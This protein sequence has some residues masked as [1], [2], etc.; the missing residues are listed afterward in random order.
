MS[1]MLWYRVSAALFL[2]LS[3]SAPVSAQPGL[4]PSGYTQNFDSLG[5]DGTSPPEGWIVYTLAGSNGTFS[6]ATGIPADRVSLFGLSATQS[7]GLIARLDPASNQNNGYNAATSDAPDDRALATAPTGV[8]AAVLELTLTNNTGGPQNSLFI[9]Y[10]IRRFTVGAGTPDAGNGPGAD[11]LPGYWLFYSLDDGFT[12][13]NVAA[14]NP[15]IN[16]VPNTVGVTHMQTVFNLSSALANGSNIMLRWVDD[17][18]VPSSPDQILGLDNVSLSVPTHDLRDNLVVHLTFDGDVLDHTGRGNDG[19]IVRGGVDSPFVPGIITTNRVS[20]SAFRTQGTY[21]GPN[22]PT[23]NYITLGNPADLDFGE[24]IDITF[25]YWGKYAQSGADWDP[26]WISNK[27]WDSGGNVGYVLSY[28]GRGWIDPKTGGFKWNYK[29]VNTPRQDS[30][31]YPQGGLDDDQW[32]HYVVTFTRQGDGV[33]YIDGS[34]VDRRPLFLTGILGSL[35]SGLPV[36]VMQDGK[37]TYT[38]GGNGSAWYDALISDLGIWRRA[39]TADEVATI[40][41][42]GLQGISAFDPVP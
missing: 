27:N 19:A 12:Y 17:N 39:I 20:A 2:A 34:E 28:Q 7:A 41:V 38:D 18:G 40:Y 4:M 1:K 8:A 29:T 22:M 35:E 26:S 11:E 10:D 21:L 25:S 3:L 36:N 24:D 15:D 5:Q 6:A 42:Q 13:E 32:H 31:R 14:L 23:N 9:S 30:T 37:G 16:S 33:M